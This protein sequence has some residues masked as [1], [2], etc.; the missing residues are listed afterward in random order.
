MRIY[1]TSQFFPA[2]GFIILIVFIRDAWSGPSSAETSS[3][4]T[5][6]SSSLSKQR[7]RAS[8][9]VRSSTEAPAATVQ[10]PAGTPGRPYSGMPGKAKSDAM[11]CDGLRKQT[12]C[13]QAWRPS[14]D[15]RLK[16]LQFFS[17]LQVV[18]VL[19]KLITFQSLGSKI[20]HVETRSSACWL[21]F[22]SSEPD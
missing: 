13:H 16:T 18:A 4:W 6:Q 9:E 21:N 10:V 2:F 17:T 1:N 12:L 22:N 5:F 15:L 11:S 3:A 14:K 8:P 19:N 7:S 20:G